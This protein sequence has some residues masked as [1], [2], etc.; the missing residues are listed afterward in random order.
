[1]ARGRFPERWLQIADKHRRQVPSGSAFREYQA[2]MRRASA[3]YRGRSE[4]RSN[5]SSGS[6]LMKL[7]VYAG[8]GYL[9]LKAL[10]KL[11]GQQKA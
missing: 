3:E 10:G 6:G 4:V 11:P 2:A 7:V 5:P 1:M 9:A 8:L